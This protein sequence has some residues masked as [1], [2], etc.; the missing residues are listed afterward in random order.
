[1]TSTAPLHGEISRL[2]LA[3]GVLL[4][5]I[6]PPCLA[7][8]LQNQEPDKKAPSASAQNAPDAAK[9]G[10]PAPSLREAVH[11]KKVLT[12]DDLHPQRPL[13]YGDDEPAEFNPICD[14]K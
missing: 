3:V 4:I 2:L 11:Q 14:P 8:N 7:R 6:L 10:E 1:M 9:P 12:E 13:R 5:V